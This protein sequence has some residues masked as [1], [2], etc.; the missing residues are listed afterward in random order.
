MERVRLASEGKNEKSGGMN[1]TEIRTFLLSKNYD[2]KT[3]RRMPRK[4]LQDLLKSVLQELLKSVQEEEE[5]EQKASSSILSSLKYSKY[6]PIGKRNIPSLKGISS[7]VFYDTLLGDHESFD[8]KQVTA[9][10]TENLYN[11]QIKNGDIIVIGRRNKVIRNCSKCVWY[12]GNAVH[13]ANHVDDEGHIPSS[14]Q[15]SPG[16]FHPRYWK[17]TVDHNGI[18]WPCNL[19]RRQC[20]HN[21]RLE[22][23]KLYTWFIHDGVKEYVLYPQKSDGKTEETE[24]SLEIFKTQLLNVKFSFDA[25]NLEDSFL[26]DMN[27]NNT[28][29][30]NL[31]TRDES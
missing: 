16:T 5:E 1:V 7:D 31:F 14:I 23:G 9:Y 4:E 25:I 22:N 11:Q 8:I 18:Y 30:M 24:E 21:A 10:I 19:Y 29:N 13:L 12:D 17:I 6:V 2:A 20:L 27:D 26:D 28:S 3:V 15:V